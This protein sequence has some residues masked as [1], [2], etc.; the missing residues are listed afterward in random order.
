LGY[1]LIVALFFT[2]MYTTGRFRSH[3]IYRERF[4]FLVLAPAATILFVMVGPW[5]RRWG[6]ALRGMRVRLEG[7]AVFCLMAGFVFMFGFFVY[8]LLIWGLGALAPA[9]VHM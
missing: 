1:S 8:S 2:W 5:R 7:Q 4:L 3:L 9:L 6:A